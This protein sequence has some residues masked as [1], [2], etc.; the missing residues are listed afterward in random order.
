MS[1]GMLRVPPHHSCVP[2]RQSKGTGLVVGARSNL[3]A[4]SIM[5][6]TNNETSEE[7]DAKIVFSYLA[8]R[9]QISGR[10]SRVKHGRGQSPVELAIESAF[11]FLQ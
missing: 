1:D 2:F 3:S 4:L 8:L 9:R 10:S 6:F 5:D 11:I 7:I